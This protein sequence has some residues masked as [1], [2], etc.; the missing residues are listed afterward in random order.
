MFKNMGRT[1][2]ANIAKMESFFAIFE[3]YELNPLVVEGTAWHCRL[4]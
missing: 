2:W 4:A 1:T 3:H